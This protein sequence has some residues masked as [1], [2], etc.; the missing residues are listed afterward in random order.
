[1]L[2][3]FWRSA[4]ETNLTKLTEFKTGTWVHAEN[5]TKDEISLLENRFSLDPDLI[6]DALD[7]DEIPRV[8][9][10]GGLVYIFMRRASRAEESVSTTPVL[11]VLADGFVVSIAAGSI[12]E[13]VKP[14]D[15]SEFVT[16]DQPRLIL[17][18]ATAL[19]K[20]YERNVNYLTR[21][22]RSARAGL[23]AA[24]I[25]NSDFIRF[26]AI[27][28][29]LNELV[30]D[31][32]PAGQMFNNLLV[33]KYR[34]AINED[35][36]DHAEDLLQTTQ[37]LVDTASGSLKTI[38]NIREAY[39]TIMANDQTR[40]FKMLTSI[41]IIM[42]IPGIITSIYSMNVALPLMHDPRVFWIVSSLIL[43]LMA[44]A[45]ILFRKNKWI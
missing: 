13:L 27:E 32:M 30:S 2:T 14:V 18:L 35:D 43:S 44:V 33:G 41:T 31:L 8:E 4:A 26:V 12:P 16:T 1:M 42:T 21:S 17:G 20:T 9:K 40:I 38:V 24:N 10:E 25:S 23:T 34:I 6:A 3:Y 29:S 19:L 37:Q 22:I 5:P 45:A 39:S 11:L 7:P 28:D 15:V 36:K